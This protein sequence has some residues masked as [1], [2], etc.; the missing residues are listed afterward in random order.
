[1]QTSEQINEL[2]AAL[3]AVQA[4]IEN[5]DTDSEGTMGNKYSQLSTVLGTVRPV[6]AKHGIA[7]IQSPGLDVGEE[8]GQVVDRATLTTRLLHTSGQWVEGVSRSRLADLSEKQARSI[9]PVN[10]VKAAISTMRRTAALA[11]TG[12]AEH[13]DDSQAAASGPTS[14]APVTATPQPAAAPAP[15][16]APTPIAPTPAAPAQPAEAAPAP[17]LMQM[18]GELTS[19]GVDQEKIDAAAANGSVRTM[20]RHHLQD[21]LLE[22]LSRL[23]ADPD[24]LSASLAARGAKTPADLT[25]DQLREAVAAM[26][27]QPAPE[28]VV[29]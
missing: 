16:A 27:A 8:C 28:E 23:N 25:I 4:E 2:A 17:D 13:D 1:M 24:A 20:L 14:F 15:A 5:V 22:Q 6:L 26:K 19:L 7:M 12:I 21:A 10:A 11:M 9:S 29:T 18:I 3:V